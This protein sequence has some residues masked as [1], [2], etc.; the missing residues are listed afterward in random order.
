[1]IRRKTGPGYIQSEVVQLQHHRE[2][3]TFQVISTM[4]PIGWMQTCGNSSWKLCT[5]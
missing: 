2:M 3:M 1:M 4:D 5:E